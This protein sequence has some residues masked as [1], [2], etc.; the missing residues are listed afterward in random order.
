[1]DVLQHYLLK[2]QTINFEELM[3]TRIVH[4]ILQLFVQSSNPKQSAIKCRY[5]QYF[6]CLIEFLAIDDN[7]PEWSNLITMEEMNIRGFKLNR[8]ERTFETALIGLRKDMPLERAISDEKSLE[9][10]IP[11]S[12][13]DSLLARSQHFVSQ[14]VR[15]NN[16]PDLKQALQLR[17]HL[18]LISA[19]K[20]G[21]RSQELI[22]M[23][24]G[25]IKKAKKIFG[26]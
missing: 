24:L 19:I 7:S 22:H 25:E 14:C 26:S 21:R 16:Q 20:L 8:L 18:I 2:H 10:I 5:I 17:D 11:I 3:N 9:Q 4:E 12:E 13:L 23:S 6:H 15:D 1:M